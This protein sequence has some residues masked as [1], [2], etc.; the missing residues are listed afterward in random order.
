MR[1]HILRP[2]LVNPRSPERVEGI[3][4]NVIDRSQKCLKGISLLGPH[5]RGLMDE[6]Q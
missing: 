3:Y 1:M 6:F 5:P 4:S 2:T